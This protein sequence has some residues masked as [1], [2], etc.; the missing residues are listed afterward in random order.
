MTSVR[1]VLFAGAREAAGRRDDVVEG[2]TLGDVLAVARDRYG[3]VF[4]SVLDASRVWLNGD[5]PVSGLATVLAEGDEVAILP[6]V[7]GGGGE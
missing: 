4:G 1:V 3:P 6:P 2:A 7:S 5:E